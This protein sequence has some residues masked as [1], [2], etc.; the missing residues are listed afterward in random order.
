MKLNERV[1][2]LENKDQIER[3]CSINGGLSSNIYKIKWM[4]M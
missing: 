3:L 1:Q 2:V 4:E